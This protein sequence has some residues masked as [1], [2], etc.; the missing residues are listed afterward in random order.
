MRRELWEP[1][2]PEVK[3]LFCNTLDRCHENHD[4]W[5]RYY[6]Q[7]H[8]LKATVRKLEGRVNE[9]ETQLALKQKE[10]E[11]AK[12]AEKRQAAPFS[13]GPPKANPRKPGRPEGHAGAYRPVPEQ[14]DEV[15]EVPLCVCPDCQGPVTPDR[16]EEQFI[17][18]LEIRRVVRRLVFES[19]F[20]SGCQRRVKS[21]HSTQLSQ[22]G[23]AAKVQIG[24][25]AL[26]L[27]LELKHRLGMP[28]RKIVDLFAHQFGLRLTPGALV[29]AGRRAVR[30]LEPTH[31]SLLEALR[32]SSVCHAD[33]T[34]WKIGGRNAWLWVFT[35]A[36]HTAYVVSPGRGQEI[37][38]DVLGDD[39]AGILVSDCYVAYDSLPW[40]K[41]K[42]LGHII[43]EMA[44]LLADKKGPARGFLREALKIFRKA[45]ELK[46]KKA[47][48]GARFYQAQTTILERQ[49]NYLLRG[50]FSD[51]D[52][53][54]LAN[55]FRKQRP[56]LLRFLYHD[57]VEPTNN[58]AERA[59]RPA[60]IARKLSGCNRTEAGAHTHE[61]LASLAVTCRQQ[62]L[63]FAQ[64]VS[65]ALSLDP[66][67]PLHRFS[68]VARAPT[69]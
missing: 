63:D 58:R 57:Q 42:C 56:H 55:R 4:R 33:E 39:Y 9:L 3:R 12:R 65:S 5:V 62:G 37:V 66:G 46:R 2:L 53:V 30:R 1:L 48:M 20:C 68:A 29:Q 21:T 52:N 45:M 54:R 22:A 10:L 24:E 11:A 28:Y 44:E 15:V 43:H 60:V 31:R 6:E 26:A 50:N 13:K 19:G 32:G 14:V 25:Q 36:E 8:E 34:G 49:L 38:R 18:D 67:R 17:E 27:A 16:T 51:P 41:A 69:P 64:L 7:A 23:G 35:N 40:A 59:I 47:T 61:V